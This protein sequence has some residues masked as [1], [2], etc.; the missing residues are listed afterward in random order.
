MKNI[1]SGENSFTNSEDDKK[2][3]LNVV[4]EKEKISNEKFLGMIEFA[5]GEVAKLK[6]GC[7][8]IYELKPMTE[9]STII[10]SLEMCTLKFLEL[11][12]K[13]KNFENK[14]H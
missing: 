3:K 11:I 8:E 9:I 5:N 2:L 6:S 4:A 1:T 7:N 14:K 13:T 10:N 12:E